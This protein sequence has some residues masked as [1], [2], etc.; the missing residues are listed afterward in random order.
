[1]VDLTISP[2]MWPPSST[3]W[4]KPRWL[5]DRRWQYKRL[6]GVQH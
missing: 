5:Q 3:Q 1:M 2:D 6:E 4:P